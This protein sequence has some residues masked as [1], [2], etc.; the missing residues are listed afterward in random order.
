M[1]QDELQ[2]GAGREARHLPSKQNSRVRVPGAAPMTADEALRIQ[3]R[4]KYCAAYMDE[5]IALDVLAAEVRRL[6][7]ELDTGPACDSE[8]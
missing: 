5:K 4:G 7:A 2:R 3:E 6:R 1:T 8:R